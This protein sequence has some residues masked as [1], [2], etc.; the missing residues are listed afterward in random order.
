[1]S[2]RVQTKSSAGGGGANRR[3]RTG[4]DLVTLASPV[5]ELV[6][7]LQAGIVAPSNDLRPTAEAMLKEFEEQAEN[8]RFSDK[9][10]QQA[11]FALASFV[12]ET[13]LTNDFPLREE[14]EKYALQLQYFGE[15]LAGVKFFD[16]LS[17]MCKNIDASADAVELYYVCL[18]LGF[19]GKY[20]VYLEHELKQVIEQTAGYLKKA[21]RLQEVD[22]S[23]HWKVTDQPTPQKP[24]G[25]PLWLVVGTSAI[26]LFGLVVYLVIWKLGDGNLR[27]ALSAMN[28]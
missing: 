11:K 24:P 12:D 10:V 8:L 16:R 19:K 28:N 15:Q 22:L 14:W 9:L 2:V 21:G 5:L 27:D 3:V 4:Y 6:L 23:P 7:K 26:C 25:V 20:K 13:V 18:L 17:D 1:M